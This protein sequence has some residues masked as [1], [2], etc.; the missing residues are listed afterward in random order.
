[1]RARRAGFTVIE[2]VISVGIVA[3]IGVALATLSTAAHSS[4]DYVEGTGDA[5]QHARVAIHRI[6]SAVEESHASSEFP[7]F[8]VVKGSAASW[9]F[10]DA[11]AIWRPSGTPANPEGLPL[12]EELVVITYDANTPTRL[13]EITVP[14]D[15]STV[16]VATDTAAWT[17][18]LASM[19]AD[20][21]MVEVELTDKLKSEK[22]SGSDRGGI[23]FSA[24]HHPSIAQWASYTGGSTDFEDLPWVQGIYSSQS[25]LRQSR[26]VFDFQLTATATAN[27]GD[28]TV[29]P[30]FG[31]AAKYYELKP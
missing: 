20:A 28:S 7:A 6:R 4:N 18:L 26:V 12:V 14:G 2:M 8:V 31:S 29:I 17:S 30:F 11:L 3:M 10:Y 16:P 27:A 19:R 9:D 24:A 21:G 13:V 1:M 5:V 22:I 23:Q 15:T 25:G